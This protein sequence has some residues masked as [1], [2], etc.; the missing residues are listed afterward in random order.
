M[1]DSKSSAPVE[2]V[3]W[4]DFCRRIEALGER[5]LE[6]DY[7]NT[8]ADQP[9][10]IA[11]LAD[12]VS[13]W[14]GYAIGHSDTTA[15]FFHRSNDLVTQWGGPNQDNVYH[16]ARID[17]RRRYR[18][19]G[20][21]N[22]CEEFVMTLRRDFMHMPVWGTLATITAS[23]RGI[24]RGDDFEILLGGDGSD[25]AFTQIPEEVKTVS[26]RE[27][28][29]DWRAEEPAVFTI[30]CLDDVP[31]PARLTGEQ[32]VAKLDVAIQQVERSVLHW[33][34]YMN[35]H[36]AKGVDKGGSTRRSR[37]RSRHRRGQPPS[38]ARSRSRPVVP[39][40]DSGEERA[41]RARTSRQ[42]GRE[43]LPKGGRSQQNRRG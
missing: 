32:V 10:G 22:S 2:V 23:E 41:L 38:R 36:R 18:I 5:I 17:A 9:E 19:R 43:A 16:H 4:R 8:A 24:Q 37:S 1:S 27:Y 12:Q 35:E 42:G 29:L 13:C 3:A 7:P 34:A 28:Y 21:M 15:P 20:N 33:N 39:T 30:E 26:L 14:L 25:P 40:C 31:A 11:H 6:D